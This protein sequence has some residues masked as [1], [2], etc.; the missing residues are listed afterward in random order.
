MEAAHAAGK[1]SAGPVFALCSVRVVK[2]GGGGDVT[3]L[4]QS[5][6]MF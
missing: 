1:V 6:L 5:I 4:S 2:G 3:R